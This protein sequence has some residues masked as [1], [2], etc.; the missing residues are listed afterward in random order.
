[1]RSINLYV[2]GTGA[3]STNT[4]SS[5]ATAKCLKRA[6][7]G[8]LCASAKSADAMIIA[9]APS[10]ICDALAAVMSGAGWSSAHPRGPQRRDLLQRRVAADAFVDREVAHGDDLAGEE[11]VV[12]VRSGALM[13][14]QRERI[15][16]GA[17]DP[18]LVGEHLR[19]PELDAERVVRVGEKLAG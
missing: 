17:G 11:S 1:M 16:L 10:V 3:E 14:L 8:R 15:H 12:G 19:D 7:I 6:R 2:T 9:A 5:A 13:R 18:P 4:G